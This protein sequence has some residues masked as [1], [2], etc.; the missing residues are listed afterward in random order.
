MVLVVFSPCLII[1]TYATKLTWELL[2][3]TVA[4]SLWCAIHIFVS[5]AVGKATLGFARPGD[6]Q[7]GVY[8]IALIWGNAASLPFLLLTS[9]VKRKALEH[10]T[11]AFD[12][13]I[14]YCFSYLIPWWCTI[15]SLGI[16][17]MRAPPQ[18]AGA[19]AA[20]AAAAAPLPAPPQQGG[21]GS[22]SS[23]SAPEPKSEPPP[24]APAGGP[25]PTDLASVLTRMAQQPPVVATFLGVFI[26][27]T[28]I[29]GLFWGD[30]PPFEGVGSVITLVGGGS[31]PCANVVLAGS[32]F[33]AL[34]AL[35]GDML[36]YMGEQ[37]LPEEASA[38]AKLHFSLSL[39]YRVLQRRLG[40]GGGAGGRVPLV[41]EGSCAPQPPPG[42][43]PHFFSAR[44]TAVL[45]AAR[46]VLCPA[47]SFALFY[48]CSAWKVPLLVSEDPMLTLVVLLQAAMPSAQT[49]LVVASTS[50]NQKAGEAL[51]LLFL[52]MYPVACVALIPW[53]MLAISF[54]KV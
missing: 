35:Q 54:A 7:E 29:K 27:L 8:K 16:E 4:C 11:T 25:P 51:S 24:P 46:L 26:G 45:I 47:L 44:T 20:A 14:A 41:E 36:A 9:L 22:S 52:L 31:I 33:A 3:N 1:S 39:F 53:L 48:C 6:N 21:E 10:D 23:S 15:Y 43:G 5:L 17:L 18:P 42:V 40:G 38:L 34:V 37:P 32:L 28:P 2:Q 19:A 50:G 12:R 49:L 13:G 30:S